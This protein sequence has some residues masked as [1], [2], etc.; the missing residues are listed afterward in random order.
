[1]ILNQI[2]IACTDYAASVEFYKRLGLIRIVDAP[3]RYARVEP[4]DGAGA[5]LSL[6]AVDN[7]LPGGTVTY[8]DHDPPKSWITAF[9]QLSAQG[10]QFESAPTDQ[11]WGWRDSRE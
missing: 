5:T 11:S 2:T 9:E 7:I 1:M 6:H 10:F 4:V 3:P 8:F